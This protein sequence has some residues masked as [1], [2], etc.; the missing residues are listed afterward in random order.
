[1]SRKVKN[2]IRWDNRQTDWSSDIGTALEQM[3]EFKDIWSNVNSCVRLFGGIIQDN[4]DGTV[5]VGNGGG[6]YKIKASSVEGVPA[7][8]CEPMTINGAQGGKLYYGEWEAKENVFLTNNAYNY[9][10]IVWDH[11]VD[12][13]PFEDDG[14]TPRDPYDYMDGER[15]G[16]TAIVASTY[17]YM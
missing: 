13:H 8:E 4:G 5:R 9:I 17:F 2:V 11:S 10:F 7:G 12:N 6:M 16:G 1:M 15:Y 3:D 14:V